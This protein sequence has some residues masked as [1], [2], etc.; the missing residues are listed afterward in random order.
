MMSR[1]NSII[2][3]VRFTNEEMEAKSVLVGCLSHGTN[4]GKISLK[5]K[6]TDAALWDLFPILCRAWTFRTLLP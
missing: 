4:E 6:S 2:L 1:E 3:P 5:C